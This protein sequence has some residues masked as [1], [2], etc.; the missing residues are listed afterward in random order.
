MDAERKARERSMLEHEVRR[1]RDQAEQMNATL[2]HQGWNL[3]LLLTRF[4]PA[5]LRAMLASFYASGDGNADVIARV[6][7][8]MDFCGKVHVVL[9][10]L[11]RVTLTPR[12]ALE[13]YGFDDDLHGFVHSLLPQIVF[14]ATG[15]LAALNR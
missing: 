14:A 13:S 10:Q 4:D 8:L 15:A 5:D 6:Q 12:G 2:H 9:E 1:L 7:T 3:M 11:A